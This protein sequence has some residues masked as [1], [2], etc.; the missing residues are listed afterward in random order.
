MSGTTESM[1]RKIVGA[2][3]LEGVVRSMKALAASSIGQYERAVQSVDGYYARW[4]S[5]WPLAC[6]GTDRLRSQGTNGLQA[7]G[8]L[9]RSSSGPIK[10]SSAGS[11]RCS[12]NS[13][14]AR[15]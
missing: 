3:D 15:P 6:I 11:T 1:R 8:Q 5:D 7:E 4:N 10:A 13:P 14:R 12:S 9:A 2:G